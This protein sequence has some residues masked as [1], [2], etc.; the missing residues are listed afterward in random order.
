MKPQVQILNDH[1]DILMVGKFL[2]NLKMAK[3]ILL[4]TCGSDSSGVQIAGALCCQTATVLNDF[5]RQ[6]ALLAA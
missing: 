6:L 5:V 2:R 4:L 1:F 3:T